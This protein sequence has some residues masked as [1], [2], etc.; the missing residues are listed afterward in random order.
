MDQ[1]QT[2]IVDA[3][4][5]IERRPVTGFG[6]PGHNQG[7]AM[8]RRMRSLLGKRV[9]QADVLTPKGLDDRT[10]GLLAVQRA[11]EIAAEAWGADLARFVTG[12]STQ[13]LHIALAAIARPGD[14]VLIAANAHKAEFSAAIFAG[15]HPV[16]LPV[17]VAA[18][19]D[20][21]HGVAPATLA[22]A[23]VAHPGARAAVVVSPSYYGV[24]SDIPALAAV[25]HAHGV[26]LVVD[27]AWGGAFGFSPRLPA[28]PL[29]QGADVMVS[30][31]HKTMGAL[32][33]GSVLLARGNLVDQERLALA[34]ELFETTSPSVPMLA[35]LDATRRDHATRGAALWGELL[36]LAAETRAR[37]AGID[38]ARVFGREHLSGPGAMDLD[39]S[40]I[41]IDIARW[42]IAGYAAD[43]WLYAEHRVSV[44][45]SDARHLLAIVAL[46]TGRADLAELTKGLANLYARLRADRSL[47]PAAAPVIPRIGSLGFDLAMAPP[48][49]F[50]AAAEKVP[51][52]KAEGR[53]AAEII[54]PAPPGIP[55]LIPGQRIDATHVAW[56]IANRDAGAFFLD[57]ADPTERTIRV[58]A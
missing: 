21:E 20:I 7:H 36:D 14:T 30:S 33:Q 56:L 5:A 37:L 42:G 58:V 9:F 55:R 38:G 43:D 50:F 2:P 44:G 54:A 47:L 49:A 1:N 15:L 4:A 29:A 39:E 10:E 25:A 24:T 32:A 34:Y 3:L 45:L 23:L 52:E 16:V 26:P 53:I 8:P 27:A 6:A 46:G 57:P 41:L 40:K 19:W 18:E 31:L 17:E 48:D 28:S 22:A 35:S 11:H 13:S 12:G 51:L